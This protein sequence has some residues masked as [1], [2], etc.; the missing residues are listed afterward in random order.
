MTSFQ[1]LRARDLMRTDVVSF[2]P[3][4]SIEVAISIFE[5]LHIS[6]APVVNAVGKLVGVLSAADV[7]RSE[8][9]AG[10]R[11]ETGR[12]D[13][14]MSYDEESDDLFH[15]EEVILIREDYSPLV[16]GQESVGDWMSVGVVSVKPDDTI[17]HVCRTMVK[18]G[19]H[20]VCVVENEKLVGIV[21]SFDVVRAVAERT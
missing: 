10:A 12:G 13:M 21:T 3:E 1:Q 15:P 11:I 5:D 7:V 14:S 4:T 16:R 20:R 2:G 9:V 19:F 8:H 18:G 17:A 6:G